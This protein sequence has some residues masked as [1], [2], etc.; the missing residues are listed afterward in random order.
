MND[1]YRIRHNL[2]SS[3]RWTVT[4]EKMFRFLLDFVCQETLMILFWM[5]T[6][7]TNKDAFSLP[8]ILFSFFFVCL[9]ILCE[10]NVNEKRSWSNGF[11]WPN[12]TRN[13][14]IWCKFHYEIRYWMRFECM[15]LPSTVLSHFWFAI[16][17][18]VTCIRTQ[19]THS[20]HWVLMANAKETIKV[21]IEDKYR[22]FVSLSFN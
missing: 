20:I 3:I 8:P 19:L 1:I 22:C 9:F 12:M 10:Q 7:M 16:N 4:N 2:F 18:L 14:H 5:R 21:K 17:S 11:I 6:L 13:L 15:R